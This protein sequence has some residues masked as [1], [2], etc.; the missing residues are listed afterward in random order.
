MNW[1]SGTLFVYVTVNIAFLLVTK[2]L[3]FQALF[4]S[5]RNDEAEMSLLT[6]MEYYIGRLLPE[7]RIM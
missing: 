5:V 2:S 1:F 4:C 6:P 3:Q 7:C